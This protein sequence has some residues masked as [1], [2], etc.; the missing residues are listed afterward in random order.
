VIT[1]VVV[2]R[3]ILLAPL[4]VN[5]RAPSGPTVMPL[6]KLPGVGIGN[7]VMVCANTCLPTANTPKMAMTTKSAR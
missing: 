5:H 7:S 1:P 3:P 4:S 2:M 6:G